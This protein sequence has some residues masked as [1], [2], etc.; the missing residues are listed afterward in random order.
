MKKLLTTTLL[1]I[2]SF[3][4]FGQV[5]IGNDTSYTEVEA[6]GTIEFIGE[7]TVWNDYVV[8]FSSVKAKDAK[9]PT[10]EV[11]IGDVFQW[12]FKN[13]NSVD[14]EPEVG[15]V[16]QMPHDWD[17]STIY[18]HIHWA[19]EEDGSGSVVWA[20]E[21]TWVSYNN[22]TPIEFPST[23]VLTGTSRDLASMGHKHLITEFGS[24]T[25]TS[26]QNS[27]S[28]ILVVTFYRNST[29]AEDTYSKDAFGLSFDIHYK[30]NTIGSRL[31]YTK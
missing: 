24:I 20:I 29:N 28:S 25:P 10:W 4:I 22:D 16:I 23:N 8:P 11:F 13:E 2:L 3:A 26:S 27:I 17:G 31:Q 1:V 12:A 14:K 30:S 7:A 15:F 19:P 21:Y 9:P 6:D 5:E 18:P